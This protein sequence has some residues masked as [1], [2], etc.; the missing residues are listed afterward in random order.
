MNKLFKNKIFLTM[1]MFLS[2]MAMGIGMAQIQDNDTG[3]EAKIPFTFTI[4]NTRLPAGNYDVVGISDVDSIFEMRTADNSVAVLLV[5]E[6][7]KDRLS[8]INTTEMVF[9]KI[10][11]KYFLRELQTE[12]YGYKYAMSHQEK[13]L[14]MQ[15]KKAESHRV[16]CTHMKKMSK[17]TMKSSGY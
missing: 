17:N 10:G 11:N 9:D 7:T 6:E 13:Q 1:M 2:S 5:P 12:N 3:I 4:E 14:E 16:Q 15:G 8:Q